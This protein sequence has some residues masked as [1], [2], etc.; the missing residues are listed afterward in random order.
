MKYRI[1]SVPV[2]AEGGE[3]ELNALVRFCGSAQMRSF[4]N[5]MH[6]EFLAISDLL[7]AGKN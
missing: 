1:F 5:S 7:K 2:H 3:A 4:C 6:D